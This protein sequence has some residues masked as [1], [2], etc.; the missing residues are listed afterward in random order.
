L[1]RYWLAAFA[2]SLGLVL[3]FGLVYAASLGRNGDFSARTG[4]Q[5]D[6]WTPWP[7]DTILAD[8]TGACGVG[9]ATI[10]GDGIATAQH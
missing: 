3:T 6:S 8:E 5:P 9:I 2:V 10:G 7:G 1:K 4:S